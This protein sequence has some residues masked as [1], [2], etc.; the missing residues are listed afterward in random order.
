VT[1][2][3]QAF[4]A[5]GGETANFGVEFTAS[6]LMVTFTANAFDLTL[7]NDGKFVA[8]FFGPASVTGNRSYQLA[9]NRPVSFDAVRCVGAASETCAVSWVGNN[10]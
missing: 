6:A 3:G 7:L 1:S 8:R 10:P 4:Q 5:D 2:G 9:L